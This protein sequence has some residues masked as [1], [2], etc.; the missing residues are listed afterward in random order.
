MSS[1][2]S[3][4]ARR[5]VELVDAAV[6]LIRR[7]GPL[8]SMDRIAA[9]CGVT[10]PIIYR[11]FGDRYGLVNEVAGRLVGM[12][13]A[14]LLPLAAR[15]PPFRE[16][17]TATVDAYLKVVEEEPNLFRFLSHQTSV[18]RRDLFAR[19]VADSVAADL[20]IRLRAAGRPTVAARPW[21][22]A[23]VGM[24]QFTG[25]WWI[26]GGRDERPGSRAEVVE[27]LMT[28]VWDGLGGLDIDHPPTC[29][30]PPSGA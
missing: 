29:P 22:V 4:R 7:E 9:E 3:T 20:E 12:M 2:R 8:V 26:G 23:L 10:K 27:H 6:A 18:E 1:E 19:M 21:A 13:V 5:R 15:R 28:L 17:M 25:D 30:Q 11:Y 24:V 14:E 16:H